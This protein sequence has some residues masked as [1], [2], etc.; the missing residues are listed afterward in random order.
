[1][2]TVESVAWRCIRARSPRIAPPVNGEVGSTARTAICVDRLGTGCGHRPGRHHGRPTGPGH[3]DQPVGEG[4]LPR[5]RRPGEPD[6]VG[7]L[8]PVAQAGHR[9]AERA[10]ALD[11][12]Q[13]A[14]QRAAVPL[15]GPLQQG[16]PGRRGRAQ[17]RSRRPAPL[18][19][20]A[21]CRSTSAPS[22]RSVAGEVLVAAVEVMGAGDHRLAL[23]HQTGQHQRRAAPDVGRADL[24]PPTAAARRAPPRGAPRCGCRRPCAGAR[25]RSGTALR[26]GSRSRSRRR[27]PPP[28]W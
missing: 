7:G 18:G 16:R 25:R 20:R 11:E 27:R 5:P 1:M 24:A 22:E 4:R 21:H 15:A 10:A 3:R 2:N 19:G 6:H 12:R 13:Q 9:P 8:G 14:G 28:A 26:T 23:G 17:A